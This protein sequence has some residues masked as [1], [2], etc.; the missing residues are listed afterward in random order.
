MRQ[1]LVYVVFLC[2][3]MVS[4]AQQ[5]GGFS[6]QPDTV[7]VAEP[8]ESV[9]EGP[10]A[11]L[12]EG[13]PGRAALYSLIIPGSGQIYNGSYCKAPIV[14]GV[15]GA[16]GTVM[17]FGID[18]FEEYDE[19]YIAALEAELEGIPNPDPGGLSSSQLFDLRTQ[20]NKNKQLSIVVF[21]FVWLGN[22]IEAYVDAHLKEFD[23]SDD[24]SIQ[25]RPIGMG[26]G[27]SLAQTGIV[28]RF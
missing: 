12:F 9:E 27:P 2:L 5:V 11:N 1:L 26:E 20:A 28:I 15:V 23:I 16:M 22:A 10:K 6:S 8:T 17:A 13:R 18:Q 14:W 3:P 7:E 21:S 4:Q 24:L 25:F 19:R